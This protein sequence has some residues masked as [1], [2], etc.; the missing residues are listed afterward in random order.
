MQGFVEEAKRSRRR[1]EPKPFESK[2]KLSE[3]TK[4]T[5]L[6]AKKLEIPEKSVV[7]EELPMK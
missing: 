5:E 6:A 2:K 3:K 4:S 1:V 7:L